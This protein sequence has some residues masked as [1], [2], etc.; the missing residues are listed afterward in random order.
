MAV[1]KTPLYPDAEW[2]STQAGGVLALFNGKETPLK[3]E[4]ESKTV[5]Y[6]GLHRP[7]YECT[8]ASGPAGSLT[9]NY[10]LT[11]VEVDTKAS[12]GEGLRSGIPT[13]TVSADVSPA[14]I[15]LIDGSVTV[16]L[17]GSQINDDAD[18]FWVYSTIANGTWP[19]LGRIA[20]VPIGVR[21]FTWSGLT[22]TDANGVIMT[23]APDFD[24][25]LDVFRG[26]AP[27]KNYPVR[28]N[29][30]LL[31]WG[32]EELEC[33]FSY[34]IGSKY[35]TWAGADVIDHGIIGSVLYPEGESRGYIVDA[36]YNASPGVVMLRDAFVG[37]EAS[38]DTHSLITRVC[39]PSGQLS[40]SEPDDYENFPNPN[41]RYVELSAADPETG[42]GVINGRGMFFT[43]H[44]TFGLDFNVSPLVGQGSFIEISTQIGCLGHRTIQDIGGTLIWLSESGL[45]AS[46]GGAPVVISDDIKPEFDDM[47]REQNGRVRDAFAVNWAAKKKYMCFIPVEGDDVGCSRCIVMDYNSIPGEPRFKFSI[48]SFSKEFTSASIERHKITEDSVVNFEE[49]PV[50]GDPDGYTWSYGIGDADGPESGTISGTITDAGTSPQ[51]IE[52]STASF[53]TDDIGL[54]G[55]MVTIRR[56]SDES[57]QTKLIASNTGDRLYLAQ[58]FGWIPS[59]GDTFWIGGIDAYYETPWSSLGGDWGLKKLHSI[60]STHKV[61]STGNLTV[62]VFKD[63]SSTAQERDVEGETIDLS[64]STGRGVS[65]LS[66]YKGHHF[67]MKYSNNQPNQPFTLK[68]ATLITSEVDEPR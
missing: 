57:T 44:K 22:E 54:E 46:S 8:V 51:F 21:S 53:Y 16:S 50:L 32:S 3:Y 47:I 43:V 49:Y 9:G 1:L 26:P 24:Y 31:L 11:F 64:N 2:S 36:Y 34:V 67:K 68:N 55:M 29:R 15:G 30:R 12:Q 42:C 39:R 20:R 37:L 17:P 41:N 5:K 62:E 10:N 35:A 14:L 48:Y 65:R 52:D 60:V 61:E 13:P 25:P 66:G 56:T 40:W 18:E 38:S 58:E 59:A 27:N 7:E 63:F 4:P 6:F 45:A 33:R 19:S 28:M 23:A